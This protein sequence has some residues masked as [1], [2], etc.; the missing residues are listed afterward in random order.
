M[1]KLITNIIKAVSITAFS[2][3]FLSNAHAAGKDVTCEGKFPNPLSDYCWSCMFPITI[4]GVK[5][6]GAGDA[7]DV[8]T[9]NDPLCMC[10]TLGESD[11]VFGM[12]TSF[13][14]P[15]RMIDVVR[16]P[17]C[18]AGLGGIDLSSDFEAP[19]SGRGRV[20]GGAPSENVFYQA[21]WYVNPV[22]YWMNLIVDTDCLE[23]QAFDIAYLTELD[24]LWADEELAMILAPDVFAF[25]NPLAVAACAADC[26]KA[27]KGFG[28]AQA[29]WCAGCQGSVLP[30]TGHVKNH[31]GMVDSTALLM[32][33]FV[34]KGHRELLIY[35]GSRKGKGQEGLCY[36]YP[37]YI[38]D[39]TDYKY[40]MLFPTPQGKTG[41]VCCQP[42]GRS[43][44]LWGAGK[45][46]PYKG[47]DAVYQIYRK[48]DCCL[49][50]Q[51]GG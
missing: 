34:H 51:L 46:F 3:I 36:R 8:D 12:V 30:A 50:K 32:Q 31:I 48:R 19:P 5:M 10:G 41:G 47:E 35:S 42:F 6:P 17:F 25:A 37:K 39:K 28:I 26:I 1:K 40:T 22:A 27:N 21:H 15:A 20:E 24:P 2:I 49:G 4:A 45:E 18:L 11:I 7:E 23:Q 33:R 44:A 13:W 9:K 38:M 16:K 43:S 14:E 29:Y